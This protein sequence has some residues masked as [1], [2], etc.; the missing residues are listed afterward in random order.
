M[1][2]RESEE[3]ANGVVTISRGCKPIDEC[4]AGAMTDNL[5]GLC[6]TDMQGTET[7]LNCD[8]FEDEPEDEDKPWH[9]C[10]KPPT[11]TATTTPTTTPTTTKPGINPLSH[12]SS[13]ACVC[14]F[15]HTLYITIY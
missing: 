13:G 12:L 3:D 9:V 1:C 8:Y 4:P 15:N 6:S 7:C 10:G 11:T 14:S 2:F 5:P